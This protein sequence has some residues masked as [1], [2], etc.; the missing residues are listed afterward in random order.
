MAYNPDQANGDGGRR[1]NGSRIPNEWASNP[2]QDK[3]GDACDPDDD[4]DRLPDAQEF[5]GHC[6]YRLVADSDG[7]R[8]LDGFEVATG[9]DPCN[10]ASKPTW[11]GGSESDGDGLPDGVERGGYNTCAFAGD[12]VPGWSTCVV[13]QDGDGDGCSDFVEVLDLNGDRK[14][15]SLDV[16]LMNS[17]AAGKIPADDAASERIFDVNKD[18]KVNSI[19]TGMMNQRNCLTTPNQLGCPV[20]PAE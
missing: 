10:A 13:P 18:G 7:D 20:C 12:T 3:M 19:D 14:V 16:G 9:Y 1:P 4:N 8:V 15:N 11:E 2:S 5:D 17:R 6:P